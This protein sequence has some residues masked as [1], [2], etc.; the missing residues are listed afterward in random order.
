[1]SRCHCLFCVCLVLAYFVGHNIILPC[2]LVLSSFQSE[3]RLHFVMQSKG[4]LICGPEQTSPRSGFFSSWCPIDAHITNL[5]RVQRVYYK[6]EI[7][8]KSGRRYLAP[9]RTTAPMTTM[10]RG[11]GGIGQRRITS[12]W[13]D[14][15]LS[16]SSCLSWDRSLPF[17]KISRLMD[18]WSRAFQSPEGLTL[19][20][21]TWRD[22]RYEREREMRCLLGYPGCWPLFSQKKEKEQGP[23]IHCNRKRTL[24]VTKTAHC[25]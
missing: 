13:G 18:H 10:S 11:V 25:Q 24:R 22:T 21:S 23:E 3:F 6:G 16:S 7:K 2:V 20:L 8:K 9:D 12:G 19:D 15:F 4:P 5:W 17:C 1:M 14:F